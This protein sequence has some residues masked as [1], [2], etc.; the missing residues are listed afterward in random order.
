MPEWRTVTRYHMLS[1]FR[2]MLSS[3]R[4]VALAW[5]GLAPG[6]QDTPSTLADAVLYGRPSA[7]QTLIAGGANVNERDAGGMTPLMIA[8]SQGQTA[9]ARMLVTAGAD[10]DAATDDGATR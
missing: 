9:I 3:C 7:V 8:A 2:H 6:L 10:I 4:W 1:S 5:L